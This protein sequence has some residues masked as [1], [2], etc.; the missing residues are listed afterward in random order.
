MIRISR[1]KEKPSSIATT[2]R[3]WGN[4][5]VE[6]SVPQENHH[7]PFTVFGTPNAAP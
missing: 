7:I 1:R 6:I 2:F 4:H 3:W 5:E